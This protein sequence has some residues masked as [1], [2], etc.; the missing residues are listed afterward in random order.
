MKDVNNITKNE[1]RFFQND[2]LTELKKMEIQMNNKL[3][4]FNE[5][6]AS[7]TTD[8]D[9][10]FEKIFENITGLISQLSSR[11]FDNERIEELLSMKSKFRDQI[12][13]NTSKLATLSRNVE[14]SFYK[15][16]KAILENLQ[17]PGII[18]VSCKYK[19]CKLFFENVYNE[20]TQYKS[21]KQ[22]E[23]ATMKSFEERIEFRVFK[24][25]N[26]LNKLHQTIN[27][28]CQRKIDKYVKRIEQ[29]ATETEDFI[30]SFRIENSK[31]ATELIKTSTSLKID[32][33]KLE[34]IKKEIYKQYY[35]ELDKYKK[36]NDVTNRN[37][38]RQENEFKILKQRFT[39]L[40]E[41]LKDF[42]NYNNKDFKELSKN[43]DFTK[44][45]K[46]DSNFDLTKYDKVSDNLVGI[47]RSPSPKKRIQNNN[48]NIVENKQKRRE[49]F[50]SVTSKK[51]KKSKNE[52]IPNTRQRRNSMYDMKKKEKI[53][54]QNIIKDEKVE[55][56]KQG[57]KDNTI[58]VKTMSNFFNKKDS[59][60]YQDKEKIKEKKELDNKLKYKRKTIITENNIDLN[61][62]SKKSNYK[63]NKKIINLKENNS[64]S[65]SSSFSYSSS[66][67]FHNIGQLEKEKLEAG[68]K[69]RNDKKI[70]KTQRVN[71]KDTEIIINKM[72]DIPKLNLLDINTEKEN[73]TLRLSNKDKL[74]E[75]DINN[76]KKIDKINIKDKIISKEKSNNKS[77][78]NLKE[79]FIVNKYSKEDGNI[80]NLINNRN[81]QSNI[82]INKEK[83]IINNQK[84][85]DMN[86]IK[87]K[88]IER[89][90]SEIK[91]KDKDSETY[92]NNNIIHNNLN[93]KNN[94]HISINSETYNNNEEK[95]QLTD[96]KNQ[97]KLEEKMK[98]EEEENEEIN[99][100]LIINGETKK[101]KL[102]ERIIKFQSVTSIEDK[103]K[104]K[105]QTTDYAN[106]NENNVKKDI[107]K[108][109]Q[110]MALPQIK[111]ISTEYNIRDKN[112]IND[113]TPQLTINSNTN[114]ATEKN[115]V[116]GNI[117]Q[118]L[119]R[120]QLNINNLQ[121]KK[122]DSESKEDYSSRKII[123][124]GLNEKI[125][126]KENEKNNF[127]SKNDF[128]VMNDNYI[129][130]NIYKN[131]AFLTSL[132][133]INNNYNF[134]NKNNLKENNKAINILKDKYKVN[135]EKMSKFSSKIDV[136]NL[137]IKSVNNRINSLEEKYQSILNQLNN[138]LKILSSIYHHHRRKSHI[139]N[140]NENSKD[141]KKNDEEKNKSVDPKKIKKVMNKI[142]EL[143]NDEDYNIQVKNN[144]YNSVVKKIEPY[145]IKKFKSN[146]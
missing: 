144:N 118:R 127:N 81:K 82:N 38:L 80:P 69:F 61:F 75:K 96:Y 30:R 6:L 18:G 140:E 94:L 48:L 41:Y 111:T 67:S 117:S 32:W 55:V 45:Q 9:S 106:K 15:Y 60:L 114:M 99:N 73:Y 133:S 101:E 78:I 134:Y 27:E 64:F 113:N 7:K 29:R 100:S 137:N 128:K 108:M 95:V 92:I 91:I 21:F 36:I 1:M 104:L 56:Q 120:G 4:N 65:S 97:E 90:N 35:E 115:E 71:L 93:S 3:K 79:N 28:I 86:N 129:D 40:A 59:N 87:N 121:D 39:Q 145:L 136:I 8:Y 12:Y 123:I 43:I 49:S 103:K 2:I 107:L 52:K 54:P 139:Q 83:N 131:N 77:K 68:N 10:K 53:I 126:E 24:V 11:K 110:E 88:T 119:K 74:R 51:S 44:K 142:S 57:I 63:V 72:H 31:Y 146:K 62:E 22:E 66:L 20:I 132:N 135:E 89:K 50:L 109:D 85:I 130:N 13:E 14:N 138:V 42:R 84:S 19:N 34:N 112:K 141:D 26:E 116:G 47:I 25:E 125:E 5:T 46:L 102:K 17:V 143:Y 58:H 37:F 76:E 16:D 70:N 105:L 124:D 98:K 33:E 23:K 122:K